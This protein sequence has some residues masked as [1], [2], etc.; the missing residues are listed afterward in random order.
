MTTRIDGSTIP[1]GPPGTSSAA[2]ALVTPRRRGSL[3]LL[4]LAAVGVTLLALLALSGATVAA[5]G[6]LI[7]P[8]GAL[9]VGTIALTGLGLFGLARM[10]GTVRRSSTCGSGGC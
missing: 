9:A 7:E 10:F 5:D 1:S 2:S 8:F 4:S 6:Q 3:T